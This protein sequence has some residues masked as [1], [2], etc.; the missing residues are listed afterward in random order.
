MSAQTVLKVTRPWL[1]TPYRHRASL[2]G[3]G[4]DCLGLLRGVWRGLHGDEP[5]PLPAY[6][7]HWAE[8]G[9]T[10][11]LLD[12]ARAY[13]VPSAPAA[14][15]DAGD[16]IVF[17]WHPK[18]LCKHLG[19]MSGPDRFIH[20]YDRIGVVETALVTGWRRRIAAVFRFPKTPELKPWQR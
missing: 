14:Q 4:C 13:L 2:K 20:A 7:P 19:I 18:G 9:C 8:V 15:P 1:G 16:V 10:E 3:V 12:A 5:E 17:R 6:S 11:T